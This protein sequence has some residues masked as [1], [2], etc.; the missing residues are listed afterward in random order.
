[1]P[2][3]NLVLSLRGSAAPVLNLFAES[4][5]SNSILHAGAHES[6]QHARYFIAGGAEFLGEGLGHA[7]LRD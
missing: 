5:P 1:V 4:A 7:L 2:V 3:L 6:P